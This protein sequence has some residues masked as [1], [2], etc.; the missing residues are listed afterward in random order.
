MQD[1][2]VINELIDRAAAVAGS[3]YK[4]AQSMGVARQQISNWRHGHKPCPPEDWAI[5]ASMAGLEADK[6]SLRALVMRHEGTEKGDR[7]LKALGKGLLATGAVLAS[8]GASAA[9]IFSATSSGSGIVAAVLATCSTM[10]IM[11]NLKSGGGTDRPTCRHHGILVTTD[12]ISVTV[13]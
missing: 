10:Y 4:L 3:D 11:F 12:K 9:A 5:M 1:L 7:L 6:W 2:S 8:S 13:N